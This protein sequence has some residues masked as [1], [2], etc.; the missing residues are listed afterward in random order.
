MNASRLDGSSRVPESALVRI[1]AE[2]STVRD[3]ARRLL[4]LIAGEFGWV[5]GALWLSDDGLE[6]L[7]MTDDWSLDD[8]TLHEFRRVSRSLTFNPG[9]G[10]PGRVWVSGE[11][12]WIVDVTEDPNFPRAEIARR[13]GL[14]G[15]VGLP[16]LGPSSVLGVMEFLTR[17]VR[18]IEPDQLD[19]LRTLG[20]QVGQYV[21]RASA[22][23]R[24]R[25]TEDLSASIV[26][27][28]LDCVITMDHEGRVIDFNPAAEATF[29]YSR[30]DAVGNT[31]AELIVPEA[32]REAHRRAIARYLRTDKPTILNRRLEMTGMRAD[33]STL[34]IELTVT[35]IARSEPPLFAGFLRD[36]SARVRSDEEVTALLAREHEARVRAE[37]AERAARRVADAL[38]RSLLPPHLPA[39]PGVD[40]AVAYRAG[41]EG[42][43]V[44]GDFY[45]VFDLGGGRWGVAIGDV[46]GKGPDAASL[47]ALVRYAIR[48][49]AV[50][51]TSPSAVLRVVNEALV[52]DTADEDF[53][54]AIYASIDVRAPA[55]VVRLAVGGHPL[56]LLV[57][58]DA[59]VTTAG[60]A[61]TLLGAV[62]EPLLHDHQVALGPADLL[63]LY[64]DGVIESRT[65]GGR[66][67]LDGLRAL[68]GE[69]VGEDVT[70]VAGR[71]ETTV[72]DLPE[73][74]VGD[75]VALLAVRARA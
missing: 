62:A 56:P 35:R 21:A 34:P 39:I 30:D 3:A 54:T 33:G 50:R 10:L 12:A 32:L 63:L 68:L 71:I 38:Q 15:A 19:L 22:E 46:R 61:G 69:S 14:H 36:I 67:G 74:P 28:A 58:A 23:E 20:R 16:V 64:T 47:T 65:P 70:V 53:C 11:P 48:T 42:A 4:E 26:R 40:L 75:D 7:R 8:P 55:P 49:A 25:A 13:A 44:G 59:R 51:E 31:V 1:L 2:A 66:L 45:D 37:Q 29:G 57:R 27:A 9:L 52:R 72:A 5:Y 73:Q 60:R 17:D 41:S 6:L 43:V 24:L 18:E